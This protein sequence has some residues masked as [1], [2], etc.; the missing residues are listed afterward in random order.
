MDKIDKLKV[1]IESAEKLVGQKVRNENSGASMKVSEFLVILTEKQ[2]NERSYSV[3]EEFKRTGFCVALRDEWGDRSIP[4]LDTTEVYSTEVM[5]KLTD[6]YD[7]IISKD[8]V[9]VGCQTIS[10]EKIIEVCTEMMNLSN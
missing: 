6:E 5:I 4:L 1:L 10:R 7:A 8:N 3:K 9:K 2:A